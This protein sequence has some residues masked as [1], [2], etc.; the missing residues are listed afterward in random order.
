MCSIVLTENDEDTIGYALGMDFWIL[1][2]SA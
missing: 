1:A 2:K